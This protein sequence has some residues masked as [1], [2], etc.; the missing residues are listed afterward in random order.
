VNAA[1]KITAAVTFAVLMGCAAACSSR[2][3]VAHYIDAACPAAIAALPAHLPVTEKQA[4]ADEHAVDSV[5][6]KDT[7]LE[8]MTHIVGIALSDVGLHIARGRST[9]ASRATYNADVTVLK[10]YCR[11]RR[12]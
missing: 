3:P 2:A 9:S 11:A 1:L 4:L 10:S 7:M 5:H 6:T 8:A 12:T